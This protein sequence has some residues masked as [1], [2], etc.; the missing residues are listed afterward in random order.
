MAK[1]RYIKNAVSFRDRMAAAEA[2]IELKKRLFAHHFFKIA[3]LRHIQLP[4]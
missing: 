1:V 2:E 3:C 4:F